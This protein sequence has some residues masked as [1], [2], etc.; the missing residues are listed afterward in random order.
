MLQ[1][2]PVEWKMLR[3]NNLGANKDLT[4]GLSAY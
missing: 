2:P 4:F 3:R 1:A